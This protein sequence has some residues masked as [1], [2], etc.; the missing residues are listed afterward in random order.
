MDNFCQRPID[1]RSALLRDPHRNRQTDLSSLR[2]FGCQSRRY[3]GIHPCR[4]SWPNTLHS[5]CFDDRG[6]TNDVASNSGLLAAKIDLN[7]HF[8]GPWS[9]LLELAIQSCPDAVRLLLDHGADVNVNEG[10]PLCLAAELSGHGNSRQMED[11]AFLLLSRG[12]HAQVFKYGQC[13]LTLAVRSGSLAIVTL[14]LEHGADVNGAYGSTAASPFLVA[15]GHGLGDVTYLDERIEMQLDPPG[16]EI[17]RLL[18]EY[19]AILLVGTGKAPNSWLKFAITHFAAVDNGKDI[20]DLL[21]SRMRRHLDEANL[22]L[23]SAP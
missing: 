16:V 15:L 13:A 23:V 19:G 21:I 4:F 6:C 14:L 17:V 7:I 12:A 20:I 10:A 9:S 5:S 22:S 8:E 11:V 2:H 3:G 18:L 1:T